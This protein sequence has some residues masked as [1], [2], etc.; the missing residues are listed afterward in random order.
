MTT[1]RLTIRPG[2]P[3]IAGEQ[4]DALA[5]LIAPL[6][7]PER[8]RRYCTGYF[9]RSVDVKDLDKRY[10]WDLFWQTGAAAVVD[11]ACT[12]AH[13][14]TALRAIVPA[15]A[16]DPTNEDRLIPCRSCGCEITVHID[17][18]VRS[19]S[20][21]DCEYRTFLSRDPRADVRKRS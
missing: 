2:N 7:T 13:I 10:R 12:D 21:D 15:L 9:A 14:D 1:N 4:R 19:A 3:R 18:D 20:C 6:D 17:S 8:R 5:S 16:S 11:R